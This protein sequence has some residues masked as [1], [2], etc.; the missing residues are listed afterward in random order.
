M[1]LD[2]LSDQ[3][4]FHHLTLMFLMLTSQ[5]LKVEQDWDHRIKDQVHNP[6]WI[7]HLLDS[8]TSVG[9]VADC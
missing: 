3:Q 2:S 5:R 9:S 6:L 7:A 4:R 1:N 8:K